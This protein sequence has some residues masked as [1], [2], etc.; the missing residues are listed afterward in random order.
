[1]FNSP[2]SDTILIL[3]LY[4]GA[5]L[6]Q[7]FGRDPSIFFFDVVKIIRSKNFLNEI[8]YYICTISSKIIVLVVLFEL[9]SLPQ[10][11]LF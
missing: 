9:V 6:R 11:H 4:L 2:F 10:I 5:D 7:N 1:M 3:K 8:K